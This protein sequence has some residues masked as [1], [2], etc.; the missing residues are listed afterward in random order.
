MNIVDIIR[1]RECENHD[2]ILTTCTPRAT[3][4]KTSSRV[5]SAKPHANTV[6]LLF[7]FSTAW[8]TSA[9]LTSCFGISNFCVP[10]I[11]YILLAFRERYCTMFSTSSSLLEDV[12]IM[13][14]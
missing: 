2:N 7:A 11:Q 4:M 1:R 13:N 5:V 12:V 6:N 8:N 9:I 3:L 10:E 14:M